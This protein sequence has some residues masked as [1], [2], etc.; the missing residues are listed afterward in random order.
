MK[1]LNKAE[2]RK[3][4]LAPAIA[5]YSILLLIAVPSGQQPVSVA[6]SLPPPAP[7]ATVQGSQGA[8][9]EEIGYFGG[10][11]LTST[12]TPYSGRPAD[13]A[14]QGS[15]SAT[16]TATPNP[17]PSPAASI[18][19]PKP[20]QQPTVQPTPTSDWYHKGYD[21]NR[22]EALNLRIPEQACANKPMHILARVTNGSGGYDLRM[23]I[24][25]KPGSDPVFDESGYGFANEDITFKIRDG[26]DEAVYAVRIGTR[27]KDWQMSDVPLAFSAPLEVK[28]CAS[29]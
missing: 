22:P 3:A 5:L 18:S 1:N 21:E 24:Y 14:Y 25:N 9:F 12:P 10:V 2:I 23:R 6:S 28:A 7:T 27:R 15:V 26:L 17:L 29:P 4:L 8:G 11:R 16:A 13:S 19:T 20:T